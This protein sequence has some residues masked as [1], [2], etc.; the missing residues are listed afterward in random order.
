MGSRGAG[1]TCCSLP[2][3]IT[4]NW[5]LDARGGV[6]APASCTETVL[7]LASEDA[8]GTEVRWSL[9]RIGDGHNS[10]LKAPF[11]EGEEQAASPTAVSPC[12]RSSSFT[13]VGQVPQ[14]GT[15]RRRLALFSLSENFVG[16]SNI[17]THGFQL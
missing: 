9:G 17:F 11:E 2:V 4:K 3:A 5:R 14:S 10:P 13:S 7:E 8:C 15:V 12:R 6:G 16:S 1:L